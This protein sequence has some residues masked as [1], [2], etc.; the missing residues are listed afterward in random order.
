MSLKHFHI[1]FIAVSGL[2]CLWMTFWGVYYFKTSGQWTGFLFSGLGVVGGVVLYRYL[3]WFLRRYAQVLSLA[4]ITLGAGLYQL[5]PG[6]LYACSV[7]YKD[8][9]DP[10]TQ[11]AIFGVWFLVAV[12][13]AVLAGI[14]YIGYTWQKRAKS[15]HIE[16]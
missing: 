9:D 13:V 14:S 7:C 15:L 5:F 8:P 4:M 10:L 2:L 16:L 3:R 11:G 12:V 6:E 1:F